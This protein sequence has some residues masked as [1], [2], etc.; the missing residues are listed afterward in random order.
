MPYFLDLKDDEKLLFGKNLKNVNGTMVETGKAITKVTENVE[1]SKTGLNQ[2][3]QSFSDIIVIFLSNQKL[4]N[5]TNNLHFF[6][7]EC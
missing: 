7:A 3:G 1:K 6:F 2:L 5:I 4:F